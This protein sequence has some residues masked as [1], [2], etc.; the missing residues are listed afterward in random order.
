MVSIIL[1]PSYKIYYFML[2]ESKF[3]ELNIFLLI[4]FFYA[5]IGEGAERGGGETAIETSFPSHW[6]APGS[7]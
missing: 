3:L 5:D 4:E 2:W 6:R 1:C 7:P